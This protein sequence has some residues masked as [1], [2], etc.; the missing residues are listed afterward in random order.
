MAEHELGD[1]VTFTL[2]LFRN[3]RWDAEQRVTVRRWET[4][5]AGFAEP[6][7]GVI[8]GVRTLSNGHVEDMK[9]SNGYGGWV[10]V[11]TQYV[12]VHYFTA[13]LVAFELRQKPVL[14]LPE[15][16][17]AVDSLPVVHHG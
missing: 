10:S 17:V 4:L 6:R 5:S 2:P 7:V 8:V 14:C 3:S 15:H 16:V 12:G 1:W 13:Y 9:E 11:G